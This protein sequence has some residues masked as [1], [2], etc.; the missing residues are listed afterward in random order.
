MR[1]ARIPGCVK[2]IMIYS[3]PKRIKHTQSMRDNIQFMELHIQFHTVV[4]PTFSQFLR[5][6]LHQLYINNN[7]NNNLH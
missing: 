5:P 4:L 7:N 6:Q 2:L 3:L 1:A